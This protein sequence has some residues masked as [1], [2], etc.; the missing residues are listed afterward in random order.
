MA[1]I[2]HIKITNFRGIA[3]LSWFPSAG[4]NCLIGPGDSGKST[5]LDAIDLCLG[6]RRS[7]SFTD[8]DF[9][10]LD[11]TKDITIE[12]TIGELSDALKSLENYGMFVRGF[13]AA[14]KVIED[15]PEKSSETVITLRLTVKSDLDPIWSLISDRA[16]EQ[17]LSK[18]LTWGDRVRL[19]PTRVGAYAEYNLGWRRG[20]VLNR[21]SEEKTTTAPGA[22]AEAART[23]RRAFGEQAQEQLGETLKI[24][25]ET[26]KR[27]GIPVGETVKAMLDAASV[28]F[29]GGTVSLH[30]DAGVPLHSLGTGSTRLLTAGLQ[31]KAANQTSI[32]LLDELEYGLEPH[33]VI[34]L[35]EEAGA[36]E[37]SPPLQVFMST[38]SPSALCELSGDQLHVVRALINK[39]DVVCVGAGDEIQGTI[40]KFPHA[41]L[42]PSVAVCEG[43]SEV[44]FLRGLDQ[45]RTKSGKTSLT[46]LGVALVDCGGGKADSTFER[47]N[48]IHPLGYRVCIVR[49]NDLQATEAVENAFNAL[50]FSVFSWPKGLALED[51]IFQS[52]PIACL[53]Q[54]LEHAVVLHE[55]AA[56][57]QQLKSATANGIDLASIRKQVSDGTLADDNRKRLGEISRAKKNGWFKSVGDMEYIT[58]EFIGPNLK[59]CPKPFSDVIE[60]F[61]K[62]AENA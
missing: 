33:R 12:L 49:D 54:L 36:K 60:H 23:A 20:S 3:D 28:S 14:N 57:N 38:H 37:K 11:V 44:G 42:A 62:W 61:F 26:A 9:Y 22:L 56:I 10:K 51:A 7:I 50:G 41:F 13:N 45:W 55:E 53:G 5:I 31:R 52:V 6:A 34:K 4:I 30:D 24:V 17:G 48:A 16:S 29:S 1:R 19:A 43:A 32:L 47:A 59:G 40:R 39:H 21:L 2:R 35:L 18:T 15:E 58:R 25:E 46:G 27:L 8:A